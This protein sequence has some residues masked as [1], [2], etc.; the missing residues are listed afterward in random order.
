MP[1]QKRFASISQSLAHH[2]LSGLSYLSPHLG[3]AARAAAVETVT[4]ELLAHDPFPVGLPRSEPL[5]LALLSL[6]Q[7]FIDLLGREGFEPADV[8]SVRLDFLF[9]PPELASGF[10]QPRTATVSLQASSG[11]SYDVT[12]SDFGGASSSSVQQRHRADGAR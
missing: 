9:E 2:A 10:P 3:R 8:A 4:V 7:W 11:R 1:S 5:E 6:R 12:V